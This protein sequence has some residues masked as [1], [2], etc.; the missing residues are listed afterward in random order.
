MNSAGGW[1]VDASPFIGLAKIG[2][3]D[4]LL[5]TAPAQQVFIPD[6][7][8]REVLAGRNI[9]PAQ[10]ALQQG[11]GMRIV[12][13]AAPPSLALFRLDAGEA[14]VLAVALQR[15]GSAAIMDDGAGRA[16]AKA[17]NI[18][19]LGTV[20][21]LLLAKRQGHLTAIAPALRDLHAAGL[22]LPKQKLL[23]TLLQSVGETWSADD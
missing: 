17:M 13:P 5:R 8:A 9:D 20:G 21:V 10:E 4:L 1:V 2:R 23:N 11:W 12:T 18:P 16:A 15:P 3:L 7:V 14:A 6:V 19:A 22:F